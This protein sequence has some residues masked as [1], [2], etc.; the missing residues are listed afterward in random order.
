MTDDTGPR[1]AAWA[2]AEDLRRGLERAVARICPRWLREERD[3]LVQTSMVR[4]LERARAEGDAGFNATYLWKTA[5]SVVLDEVRRVRWSR[6]RAIDDEAAPP[7]SPGDGPERRVLGR[8]L[9]RAV[10]ACLAALSD[11]RRHAV[12]MRLAGFAHAEIARRLAWDEKR[13]TNLAFRGFEDLRACLREKGM[14]P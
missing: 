5:Y 12:M 3:D 6:E 4:I 13:A 2:G 1:I 10:R 11:D 7:A 9:V 14:A 8:E